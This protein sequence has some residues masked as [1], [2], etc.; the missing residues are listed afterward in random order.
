MKEKN[1]FSVFLV[2]WFGQ[3]ISS[4]GSGLTSFGLN[5][6]VFQ[7]T[8]SATACSAVM[9]CAFLPMV[10]LTP[11]S[12]ILADRHSRKTLMLIGDSFSA[13]GLFLLLLSIWL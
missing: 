13:V 1:G 3:F 6:Y 2:I 8:G 7:K 12:G 10:V 9:L 11:V 4:I 5:V